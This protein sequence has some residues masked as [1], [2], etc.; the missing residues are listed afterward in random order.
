[1]SQ[2]G[3][4][5]LWSSIRQGNETAFRQLFEEC[6]EPL[7]TYASKI[8]RDYS[9]A[10][11]SVQSLFIHLWEKHD[12]LPEVTAILPYLRSALKNKLLNALRDEHVYQK[13]VDLFTQVIDTDAPSSAALLHLKE[14]E[15]QLL[16]SIN[17]LPE[18]MKDVFYLHRIEELSVAEIACKM[19]RSQ[20][21]VRNQ[22]NTAVQRLKTIF[23]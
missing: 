8:T 12:T 3:Q 14:T 16:H 5:T 4:H 19:G 2:V 10:Q 7:F 1:M 21:T 20:Q 13:H 9:L 11:D 17:L 23:E 6:W 18:K 22:I 15:Q